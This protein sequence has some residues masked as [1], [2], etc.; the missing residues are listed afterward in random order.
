MLA[1]SHVNSKRN[2]LNHS[3]INEHSH[4]HS[5]HLITLNTWA[6]KINA[7]TLLIFFM[8]Y[9]IFEQKYSFLFIIILYLLYRSLLLQFVL[10]LFQ[11]LTNA[12]NVHMLAA[13][14]A[15]IHMDHI[16]VAA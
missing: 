6:K 13:R 5:T 14:L 10:Q 11:T 3:H 15:K 2:V 7:H 4:T 9:Y 12:V 16:H 8:Y 1:L